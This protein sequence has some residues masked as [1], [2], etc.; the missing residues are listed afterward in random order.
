MKKNI[1]MAQNPTQI[2][3][4]AFSKGRTKRLRAKGRENAASNWKLG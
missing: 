2:T 4:I 1:D 3:E